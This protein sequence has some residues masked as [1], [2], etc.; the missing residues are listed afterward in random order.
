MSTP[1]KLFPEMRLPAPA[2]VPPMILFGAAA[3]VPPN[4]RSMPSPELGIAEVPAFAENAHDLLH[5]GM[6][7]RKRL[8]AVIVGGDLWPRHLCL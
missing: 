4:P 8:H 7:A 6:L 3:G 5:G 2:A 1:A